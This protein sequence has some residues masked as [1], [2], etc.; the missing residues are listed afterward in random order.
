MSKG[1]LLSENVK[2]FN[3]LTTPP[4][5]YSH[6]RSTFPFIGMTSMFDTLKKNRNSEGSEAAGGP[7]RPWWPAH[8]L[9]QRCCTSGSTREKKVCSSVRWSIWGKNIPTMIFRISTKQSR[10]ALWRNISRMDQQSSLLFAN[11]R[12]RSPR[13]ESPAQPPK[14]WPTQRN[15][16]LPG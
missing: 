5:P 3:Q 4:P 1:S 8:W 14:P 13:T 11:V 12:L 9:R 16:C 10:N 6:T 2:F 7:R 15:Y